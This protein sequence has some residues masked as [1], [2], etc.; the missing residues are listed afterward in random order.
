M[1]QGLFEVDALVTGF[2]DTA[3]DCGRMSD[4]LDEIACE[5]EPADE[6]VAAMLGSHAIDAAHVEMRL[7]ALAS[8]LLAR[9]RG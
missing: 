6:E 3:Q 5:V 9:V 2:R 4:E 8:K 1:T 7:D